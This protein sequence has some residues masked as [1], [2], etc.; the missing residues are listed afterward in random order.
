MRALNERDDLR[1]HDERERGSDA[2]TNKNA[3]GMAA[4][5]GV[6]RSPTM[7]RR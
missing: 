1:V 7:S 5:D 6:L 3:N 2:L 4:R